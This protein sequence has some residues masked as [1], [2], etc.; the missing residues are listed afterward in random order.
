[1]RTSP[2]MAIDQQTTVHTGNNFSQQPYTPYGYHV[3]K[4]GAL[5]AFAGE[6]SALL[7]HCYLL[8]NGK[9]AYDTVLMRFHRPDSFSPFGRGGR[10]AY[11]YCNCDP[12]NHVDRDG[13]SPTRAVGQTTGIVWGTVGM[14]S[15][16]NKA[17]KAIVKRSIAKANGTPIPKEFDHTSRT[18]NA[19]IFIGGLA[20]TIIKAPG[21]AFAFSAPFESIGA[22]VVAGAG[23]GAASLAGVGKLRQLFTDMKSTYHEARSNRLPLGKLAIESVKEA[24]GW[25]R[26]VG[27]ESAILEPLPEKVLLVRFPSRA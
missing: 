24:T 2:L 3:V 19:M 26:F 27:R 4:G 12:V 15:S 20:G 5:L 10:N 21:A 23:I 6:P 8:G 18:N 1:M 9:R 22:E 14:L 11:A 25:N 7:S 13:H 16:L 17:S